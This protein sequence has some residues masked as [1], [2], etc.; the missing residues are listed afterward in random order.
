M[1]YQRISQQTLYLNVTDVKRGPGQQKTNWKDV[2][3]KDLRGMKL[4]WEEAEAA[5]STDKNG[6]RV[7]LNVS[8]W[9][10][11]AELRPRSRSSL[12]R[13]VRLRSRAEIIKEYTQ[14][15]R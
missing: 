3:K 13:S 5:A 1:D 11:A 14:S 6:V 12:E 15:H 8:A 9:T 2:V 7:W 10:R 4:T